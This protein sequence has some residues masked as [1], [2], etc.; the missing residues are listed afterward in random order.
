MV[1]V[2]CDRLVWA[3]EHGGKRGNFSAGAW[4][5]AIFKSRVLSLKHALGSCDIS[6]H[7]KTADDLSA[8]LQAEGCGLPDRVQQVSL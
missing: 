1:E 7:K 8:V 5:V 2:F 4:K 6:V 3:K